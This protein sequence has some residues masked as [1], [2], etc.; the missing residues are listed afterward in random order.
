MSYFITEAQVKLTFVKFSHARYDLTEYFLEAINS[1]QYFVK[2]W[3]NPY[4]YSIIGNHD[5]YI[6]KEPWNHL[7]SDAS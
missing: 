5:S 7:V 4:K 1:E 3:N 6:A 2:T